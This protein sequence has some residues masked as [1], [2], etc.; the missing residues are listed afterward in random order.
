M[1]IYIY[2]K[3]TVGEEINLLNVKFKIFILIIYKDFFKS[4]YYANY[5]DTNSSNVLMLW[6]NTK[7]CGYLLCVSKFTIFLMYVILPLK[8]LYDKK[9]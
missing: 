2:D 7:I 3:V 5:F 4:F 1:Y 6:S 9:I 8:E